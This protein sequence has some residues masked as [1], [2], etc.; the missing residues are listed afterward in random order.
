LHDINEVEMW[1]N[2]YARGYPRLRNDPLTKR[3]L[4]KYLKR[5]EQRPTLLDLGS[6]GCP[7]LDLY[8]E[9]CASIDLVDAYDFSQGF[10]DSPGVSFHQADILLL[11]VALRGPYDFVVASKL[12]HNIPRS[13]QKEFRKE[14]R[15]HSKRLLEQ[16]GT[17]PI[18]MIFCLST[19]DGL[20]RAFQPE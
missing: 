5:Y 8:V 13:K 6:G 7:F 16:K 20:G 10:K 18:P 1:A 19:A 9:Y 14:F 17:A 2:L 4:R 11:P 15:G 3:V 12:I